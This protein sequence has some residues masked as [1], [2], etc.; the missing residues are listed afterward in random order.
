LWKVYLK[1]E[2]R[3][4]NSPEVYPPLAGEQALVRLRQIE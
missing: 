3:T 1:D 4:S 2:R